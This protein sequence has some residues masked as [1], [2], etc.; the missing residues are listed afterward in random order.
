MSKHGREVKDVE[1]LSGPSCQNTIMFPSNDLGFGGCSLS[2]TMFPYN[3][4]GSAQVF[5]NHSQRKN[6]SIADSAD[7]T[8]IVYPTSLS[9]CILRN[10]VLDFNCKPTTPTCIHLFHLCPIDFHNIHSFRL[11]VKQPIG[12]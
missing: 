6:E 12:F 10:F 1:A 8:T 9:K 2:L 5:F 7:T 11:D 3:L 4:L